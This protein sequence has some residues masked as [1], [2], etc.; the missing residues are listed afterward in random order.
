MNNRWN[1]AYTFVYFLWKICLSI[2]VK[3][4]LVNL[5]ICIS[6]ICYLWELSR[7]YK[8]VITFLKVNVKHKS[9][10]TLLRVNVK[11]KSV[12]T[13]LKVN[14]KHKSVITLLKI[15][16]K[17]KSVI[18]LLTAYVNNFNVLIMYTFIC[19]TY[20]IVVGSNYSENNMYINVNIYIQKKPTNI[21]IS[22][23]TVLYLGDS[24]LFCGLSYYTPAPL[25]GRGIYC[26]TSV[27]PRY[28]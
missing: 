11:H 16:V 13:L 9:V 26:F 2:Y 28:F 24:V 4:Y 1:N 19:H 23:Y 22:G 18:T 8:S 3:Q 25:R 21:Y 12:I 20:H 27:C 15:N 7:W 10:I 5:Y 17:H 14:V 6:G